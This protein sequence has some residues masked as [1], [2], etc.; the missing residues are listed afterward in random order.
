MGSNA[1]KISLRFVKKRENNAAEFVCRLSHPEEDNYRELRFNMDNIDKNPPVEIVGEIRIRTQPFYWVLHENDTIYRPSRSFKNSYP[2][3]ITAYAKAKALGTL[4]KFDPESTQVHPTHRFRPVIKLPPLLKKG[5]PRG[6]KRSVTRTSKAETKPIVI[7]ESSQDESEGSNSDDY[8]EEDDYDNLSDT[9][10]K[11]RRK[12]GP[13]P[14]R[15]SDRT[16]KRTDYREGTQSPVKAKSSTRTRQTVIESDEEEDYNSVISDSE[17]APQPK[18]K[19]IRNRLSRPAYGTIRLIADLSENES[20]V[21][22]PIRAHRNV[23]DKCQEPPAHVSLNKYYAKRNKNRG[24]RKNPTPDEE[25]EEEQLKSLGGWVRCLKC[26]VAIHWMCLTRAQRDEIMKAARRRNEEAEKE[27]LSPRKQDT[28]GA[29]DT[30]DFFC[31]GCIQGGICM[32]C[33]EVAVA[34]EAPPEPELST[35]NIPDTSHPPIAYLE[36]TNHAEDTLNEL[37]TH[38]YTVSPDDQSRELL[39]RCKVCKRLAHYAHLPQPNLD[40]P[41]SLIDL[42]IYYQDNTDWQCT[43]C[44]SFVFQ[45]DKILAWRPYPANAVE[46]QRPDEQPPDHKS[47][48]PREYLVKWV[49]KSYRR[50]QWVP[51]MWLLATSSAKLKNFL[52]TGPRVTLLEA[53][54]DLVN[55]EQ[56]G[57]I[58]DSGVD[59][60]FF[61]VDDTAG[62]RAGSEGQQGPSGPSPDADRRIP[63]LWKTVERILDVRIWNPLK[64][65]KKRRGAQSKSS[66][67][68]S[69][70]TDSGS[71]SG[72]EREQQRTAAYASGAEPDN[73]FLESID[74]WESRNG[75]YISIEQAPDV[76]WAYI[77]WQ[78]LGYEDATWDVPPLPSDPG[79]SEFKK[80]FK[81]FLEARQ[82]LIAKKSKKEA[83]TFD[84]R[85]KAAF[86]SKKLALTADPNLGQ[87]GKLLDFQLTG[88]NWLFRNWWR[89]QPSI[90]ADDMGLGKTVQAST[91][92]GHLVK[93]YQV[94]PAL[95]IVPNSTLTNWMRELARWAPNVRVV[96]YYGESKAREIIR[97]YELY[98]DDVVDGFTK[99]KF[100]VLVTTYEAVIGREFSSVFKSVPRWELLIV[101]EA[102]RCGRFCFII[103]FY[104]TDMFEVKNDAS[105][106]FRRLNEL[107]L[108]H[109]ILMTG[110]PLNNN[111][112]ELFNL[113]NFLDPQNW[114]DVE[115]LE[116][117]YAEI[118]EDLLM[119]L[120]ERLK[121]YFLRRTKADVLKLP[122]KNEVIVPLSMT[123]LQKELYKSILSK[124]VGLIQGLLQPSA[125]VKNKANGAGLKNMLMDLRKCLQH[126]YLVQ[127]ELEP[128][129]SELTPVAVHKNLVDASCKLRILQMMLPRLKARGHRV[130]LFSQFV[131]ALD[132]VD[133]FLTAEGYKFLRLVSLSTSTVKEPCTNLRQDGNTKQSQRQ[134]DMDA[135][136]Q[137]SSDYFIFI[138]STRAGGVGI[139]LW[140]ADTVIIFDPDFNPHQDLQ[141]ISRAHRYGQQKIVLVFKFMV[142]DSAEERI[143]QT[144]KKKLAL[145]HLIVQKMDE[146]EIPNDLQSILTFGTKALFEAASEIDDIKYSEQDIDKLIIRTEE[147][148]DAV[149]EDNNTSGFGFA[150][151]W[152]A[153]KDVLKEVQEDASTEDQDTGFWDSILAKATEEQAKIGA[154]EVTGRGAK[155]RAATTVK[156]YVIDVES[157]EKN[158]GSRK[159]Q[160]S[161]S[162]DELDVQYSDHGSD[163]S[164]TTNQN[165]MTDDE[166]GLELAPAPALALSLPPELQ[167]GPSQPSYQYQ[168]GLSQMPQPQPGPSRLPYEPQAGISSMPVPPK[169][170]VKRPRKKTHDWNDDGKLDCGLCQ[171]QHK[172]GDCFMTHSPENLLEYRLMLLRESTEPI[173]LRRNA[174]NAIDSYLASRGLLERAKKQGNTFVDFGIMNAGRRPRS[175]SSPSRIVKKQKLVNG[176]IQIAPTPPCVVCGGPFHLL[177]VCPVVKAG[178]KSILEAMDRVSLIPESQAIIN[179]LTNYFHEAKRQEEMQMQQYNVPLS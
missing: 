36:N 24:R 79:Y 144:G 19:R 9:S 56:K 126:P 147:E 125:K 61:I 167:A 161:R 120:H 177:K 49:G 143:V 160:R 103:K 139:N 106:L 108:I 100:H 129:G 28:L 164:S 169:P 122:P 176:D 39:F 92:I 173:S 163:G 99:L 132:I 80:A 46:P 82:V 119:S 72:P 134:K 55:T 50:V 93:N 23:C 43:E 150:K 15:R 4:P 68:K 35:Q 22:S 13:Q 20:D 117:E 73:R 94:S 10:R 128:Q 137:P 27:G 104:I 155:R 33:R 159:R 135:F 34:P 40:N 71:E 12:P 112:R 52:V 158:Q 179:I 70:G 78:E 97:H 5:P 31:N 85:P 105:L 142:K 14:T 17:E 110:T 114:G 32:H 121:P 124:N 16:T 130:L 109:R 157:P 101:D 37:R 38:I 74:D 2:A 21:E 44:T 87:E 107:N 116:K 153:Y 67:K 69:V 29:Y 136:N 162:M 95:V 76:I 111:I 66:K 133:D 118:T 45:L 77:K 75:K 7:S 18:E 86:D 172:S 63:L 91:F 3:L 60:N 140:S 175:P 62:Q 149:A 166:D 48:L 96:P 65:R 51:H 89:L 84:N 90:L 127:R 148:G 88:V 26:T 170:K 152:E 30:T 151:L 131:I 113:M 141:A 53:P 11:G 98:H 146:G 123:S 57:T 174:V 115:A 171:T 58:N 138:L 8:G 25:D 42:A 145:D 168:A 154:A 47:M 59:P 178:S 83:V 81:S 156:S 41:L 165:Y 6:F 54:S 64:P 1:G 102:Q